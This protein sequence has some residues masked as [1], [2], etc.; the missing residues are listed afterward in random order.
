MTDTRD[1]NLVFGLDIGTRSVVGTVGYKLS[2][3]SFVVEAMYSKEHDTRAMLDGQIHDIYKV[4]DTVIDVKNHLE[5][6][7]GSKLEEVCIA[8]AGR[9]LI[10]RTVECEIAYDQEHM[11]CDEDVYSLDLKGVEEAYISLQDEIKSDD[12]RFYCVGYSAVG[13]YLN[14]YPISKLAGHRA[15]KVGVKLLATFLPEEVIEGLYT[16]VEGA[17][18]KV[19]NLT[20]EP[21]AAINVAIP[22]K[23]RLL[24]LA[25]VDVGAGTSDICITNDGTV[26]A[27]GMIPYAGDEITEALARKYLIE[28]NEA[29]RIKVESTKKKT[30]AFT[31]VMGIRTKLDST[32]I[33]DDV[34][35]EYEKITE[36]IAKK[37]IEL[38]GNK[39]VSAVFVVGGGGKYPGFVEALAK[40]LN[41]PQSRA[42]LRGEEVLTNVLFKQDN[43]RKDSML[44]T[45]IG[46][47]LNYY[48]NKNT[49]VN[50]KVNNYKIK[51]FD[52][53]NL[54][55][56]DAALAIGIK[57]T[58]LFAAL[59]KN[60]AFKLNG[61]EHVIHGRA[62]EPA[63]IKLNGQDSSIIAPIKDHDEVEIIVSTKGEAASCTL[64]QLAGEKS[65]ITVN[66]NGTG[67][68][69]PVK[70]TVN[71]EKVSESYHINS[72]D[73]V[74]IEDHIQLAD[75]IMYADLD[76]NATYMLNDEIITKAS[77]IHENDDIVMKT[78]VKTVDNTKKIV[79]EINEDDNELST[80]EKIQDKTFENAADIS[81]IFITV[82]DTV[83]QLKGKKKYTFVDILDFYPFDT[84][85]LGGTKLIQTVNGVPAMFTTPV[86]EGDD[87]KLYWIN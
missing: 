16:C 11:V 50:V 77:V 56:A 29:E 64:G 31:D 47:C 21:I 82:N 69:I 59:G 34:K 42:A 84:S 85:R 72:G 9:V 2:K 3:N 53:S 43:I 74:I 78:E 57:N 60:L 86:K 87:C 80:Q 46:I 5:Q 37:I 13:Y 7:I 26:T 83:V 41:L 8:A 44:V 58:Q 71:D 40:N 36:N 79:E 81:S 75:L 25:L 55:V 15:M 48:N 33:W 52:N 20:L 12:I 76:E 63:V 4:T 6:M 14:G 51:I 67:L 17:G 1:N 66:V 45:P 24:N 23:F 62:G 27:Y 10:T 61:K 70:M 39:P 28:F 18:L 22:E 73:E 35:E 30:V 32:V 49:F 38:N 19:C 68:S 54:T 65:A